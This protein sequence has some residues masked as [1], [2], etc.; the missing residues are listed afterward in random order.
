MWKSVNPKTSTIQTLGTRQNVATRIMEV[1]GIYSCSS[2]LLVF[3]GCFQF[4]SPSKSFMDLPSST[5]FIYENGWFTTDSKVHQWCH[6]IVKQYWQRGTLKI[7]ERLPSLDRALAQLKCHLRNFSGKV[8][9]KFSWYPFGGVW[10][11]GIHEK[12]SFQVP[13]TQGSIFLSFHNH[14]IK[15]Y[16]NVQ[17]KAQYLITYQT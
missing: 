7:K 13:P 5:L 16:Q 6:F 2:T 9:R 10:T 8:P 3:D 11:S 4:Q 17:M 15:M 14:I 12:Y 1:S